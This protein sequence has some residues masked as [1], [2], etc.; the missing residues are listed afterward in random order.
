[1]STGIE[2]GEGSEGGAILSDSLALS[3][4]QVL[5]RDGGVLSLSPGVAATFETLSVAAGGLVD[6]GKGAITVASGLTP[7]QAQSD[8]QRSRGD[9]TW[10]G[11]SGITSTAAA[12]DLQAGIVRSVGWKENSD[13]SVTV[14][15]AAPGDTD[16]SGDVN[17]FDLVGINGSGSY[18]KG[19]PS[20][21]SQGDFDYN[22]VTNIF[23]MVLTNGAGVYGRG[24]YLP[25][26][27]APA[28][29]NAVPAPS[30]CCLALFGLAGGYYSMRRRGA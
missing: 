1:M 27:P 23:D 5:V 13:G 7:G 12:A 28:S 25:A 30:A 17:V 14:A 10:T 4:S 20:V 3:R 11:T 8:L 16:L 24:S 22:G 15:Y 9:G 2:T 26:A 6:V 18:G 19:T 29:V 21:W